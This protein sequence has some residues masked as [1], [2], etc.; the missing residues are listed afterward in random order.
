MP[1]SITKSKPSIILPVTTIQPTF[2]EVIADVH[3]GAIPSEDIWIS[4]YKKASPSVHGKVSVVLDDIDRD[5]V[6]FRTKEGD[7]RIESAGGD[8]VRTITRIFHS[9]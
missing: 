3:S 1:E 6:Q 5:L 9:F 8:R 7:V 4:C 2:S